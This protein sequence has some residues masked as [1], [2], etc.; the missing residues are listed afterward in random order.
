[1]HT[2]IWILLIFT[3]MAAAWL[4]YVLTRTRVMPTQSFSRLLIFMLLNM[5]MVFLLCFLFGLII[6]RFKNY[7]FK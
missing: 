7:F 2:V 3:F 6:F 1:M 5:A 4:F